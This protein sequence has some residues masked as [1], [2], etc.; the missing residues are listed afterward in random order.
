M[1]NSGRAIHPR[2]YGNYPRI[3]G[4]YGGTR[5]PFL[6]RSH[7]EMTSLPAKRLGLDE[8]GFWHLAG[9]QMWWLSVLRRSGIRP[10]G[11]ILIFFG[12]MEYV[13]VNGQ[14]AVAEGEPTGIRAGQPLVRG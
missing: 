2:A 12:G 1:S 4:R 7:Q 10:A 5:C 3:L 6:G 9:R 14:P 11:K 13:F 8:R